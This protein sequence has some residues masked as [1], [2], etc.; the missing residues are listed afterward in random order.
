MAKN[1]DVS[2]R[3]PPGLAASED[4]HAGVADSAAF[5]QSVEGQSYKQ[6]GTSAP[7][8]PLICASCP[9]EADD[10]SN[11]RLPSNL[12]IEPDKPLPCTPG[13][14]SAHLQEGVDSVHLRTPVN[15]V[16][17]NPLAT[18]FTPGMP[19][20]PTTSAS[21]TPSMVHPI[22]TPSHP[23]RISVKSI[24]NNLLGAKAGEDP[25]YATATMAFVRRCCGPAQEEHLETNVSGR[26]VLR[27]DS[28]LRLRGVA[29]GLPKEFV[30]WLCGQGGETFTIRM[31]T[32]FERKCS[33]RRQ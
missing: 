15:P 7:V 3:P 26:V 23:A 25:E 8:R 17:L 32:L 2:T 24:I 9:P 33:L 22:V 10:G 13:V 19:L 18:T 12:L 5:R 4:I 1:S 16:K 6:A 14:Q 30:K 27:K 21:A 28:Q 20:T 29:L 31:S 11:F